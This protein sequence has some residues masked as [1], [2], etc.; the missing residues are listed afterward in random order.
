MIAKFFSKLVLFR[1]FVCPSF[2]R[3]SVGQHFGFWTLT[4]NAL[5]NRIQT[6][7]NLITA[8]AN[9]VATCATRL[10]GCL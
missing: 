8:I 10:L 7:P 1:L 3:L 9:L 4:Q 6:F 5:S 2:V